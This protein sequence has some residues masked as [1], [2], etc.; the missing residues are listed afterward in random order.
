[1]TGQC[2]ACRHNTAG[3]HCEQC[4]EGYYGHPHN[5]RPAACKQCTC[6]GRQGQ[7]NFSPTCHVDRVDGRPVCDACALGHIG[8]RC[9]V[10]SDGY[11]G[12]PEIN[13]RC[14]PCTCSGNVDM[15]VFGNCD[16]RTGR[17]LKCLNNTTGDRCE[18]C[19][20]GYFGDAPS[21]KPCQRK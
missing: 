18:R 14:S 17:C 5:G 21:L 8:R 11:Y 15:N 9:Q 2:T 19:K 10:C 6:P 13:G 1:M 16:R 3:H 12:R 20:D 4:K 7:N